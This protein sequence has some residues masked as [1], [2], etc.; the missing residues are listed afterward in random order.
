MR[1]SDNKDEVYV[2]LPE[3][4]QAMFAR[5]NARAMAELEAKQRAEAWPGDVTKLLGILAK[6][7]QSQADA[8]KSI[9]ERLAVIEVAMGISEG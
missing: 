3:Q 8:L 6:R 5:D 2:A 7:S 4:L 9:H 1:E